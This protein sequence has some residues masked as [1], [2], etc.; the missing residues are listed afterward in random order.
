MQI[1]FSGQPLSF[2]V[3]DTTPNYSI[4]E[5]DISA[6]AGQTGQLLFSLPAHSSPGT[7][8]NILF[9]STPVPEPGAFGL[10]VLGGVM[11]GLRHR[12]K[13]SR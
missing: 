11:F 10:F 3:T 1:T 2:F 5:A 12:K 6:Y 7:L 4:Y 9:S 8:D 13:N